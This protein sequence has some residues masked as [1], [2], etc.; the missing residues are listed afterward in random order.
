VKIRVIFG[1]PKRSESSFLAERGRE[2]QAV[3][4]Q[5]LHWP[6]LAISTAPGLAQLAFQGC[7]S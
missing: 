6:R 4:T 7:N 5:H 2:S 3:M 1:L